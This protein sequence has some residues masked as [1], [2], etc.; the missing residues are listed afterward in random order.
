MK[1]TF[2]WILW[3]V[4]TIFLLLSTRNPGYLLVVIICLLI[5]GSIISRRKEHLHW[6]KGNLQF[7]ISMVMISAA[8]NTLFAHVGSSVIFSLPENWPLVGGNITYES[9]VYGAINGLIIG[10]LYLA[11]NIL[12]LA[13]S[14]KQMTRLI[15]TAFRPISMTITVALT[16]FPYIQQRAREIKEAQ[17]IR[18][19]PMKHIRDWLPLI[20]PL[21][22]TSMESAFILAESMTARGFHIRKDQ[23]AKDISVIGLMLGTFAIFSGWIL[24]LYDYP[25]LSSI[26]LYSFGG[27]IFILIFWR[28]SLSTSTSRYHRESWHLADILSSLFFFMAIIIL[29]IHQFV[30]HFNTFY[31]SPYPIIERPGFQVSGFVLSIVPLIPI[32]F[33]SHD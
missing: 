15:P 18:G 33:S 11:F 4:F 29:L 20:I 12:N 30:P 3:T 28:S 6:L 2:A 27:L 17:M 22:V 13:L 8:I 32:F 14:I 21:L 23:T 26:T 9:L 1:N 25:T 7:L 5:L 24:R 19:N 10:A 31:Y 16:F